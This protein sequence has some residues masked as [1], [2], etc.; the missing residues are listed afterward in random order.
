MASRPL[1]KWR[2]GPCTKFGEE[3]APYILQSTPATLS[4]G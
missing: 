4:M 3:A 2:A 1:K